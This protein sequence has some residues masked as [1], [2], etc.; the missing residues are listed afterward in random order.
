MTA[1]GGCGR[2]PQPGGL[3]PAILRGTETRIMSTDHDSFEQASQS[4]Q[5]GL[6]SDLIAFMAENAKWWLIPIFTVLGLLGLLLVL[7]ATGAAPFI[8][9]LW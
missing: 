4:S 7:G 6:F 2:T 3:P 8:Y 5:G 9:V 1:G